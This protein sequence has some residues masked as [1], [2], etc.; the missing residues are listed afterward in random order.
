MLKVSRKA[1]G[2]PEIFHSI[3]GEGVSMGKPSVF[4]RLATCNLACRWCDTKYTWD[5]QNFDYRTEV[6]EL[7]PEDVERRITAYDCKH[8]VITGGEPML[9]QTELEPLLESLAADGYSFE[10]ETNG[11]LIPQPAMLSHIGQ[12]NVSPKLRTSGNPE[13]QREVPL[14]LETFAQMAN[15]YFKFVVSVESDLDEICALSDR[16]SL[17]PERVLLMPEGRTP[18]SLARKSSWLTEA[19]VRL[20]FRFATRVHILLWGDER[21]R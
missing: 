12:W 2:E 8:V 21:G 17:A 19:C 16:Y 6:V 5:W 14:A 10:V 3:Q 15:A 13:E 18:D 1:G 4:L 11:T 20:G 9:Q 7:A